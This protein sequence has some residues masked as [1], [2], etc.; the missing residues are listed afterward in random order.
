MLAVGADRAGRLGYSSGSSRSHIYRRDNDI[1]SSSSSNNS[2]LRAYNMCSGI[3]TTPSV[4]NRPQR[5]SLR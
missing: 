2:T 4:S 1:N 5:L 3:I